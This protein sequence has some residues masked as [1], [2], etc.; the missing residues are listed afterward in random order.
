[1][2]G[3]RGRLRG[4]LA[5][6]AG[7]ICRTRRLLYWR[8]LPQDSREV[9]AARGGSDA[10]EVERACGLDGGRLWQWK[11]F[12]RRERAN[13]FW[14]HGK[15]RAEGRRSC[16]DQLRKGRGEKIREESGGWCETGK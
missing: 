15:A 14:R 11:R 16:I 6:A 2:V 10:A 1:F 8:R 3:E 9:G 13:S 5:D 4:K 12:R 7:R